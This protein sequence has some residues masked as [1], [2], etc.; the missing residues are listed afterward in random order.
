MLDARQQ[1]CQHNVWKTNENTASKLPLQVLIVCRWHCYM[2]GKNFVPLLSSSFYTL[3]SYSH[4][5]NCLIAPLCPYLYNKPKMAIF[6]PKSCEEALH[7][8]SHKE[9]S[10]NSRATNLEQTDLPIRH[11]SIISFKLANR[12]VQCLTVD[13]AWAH[14]RFDDVTQ[15]CGWNKFWGLRVDC[16]GFQLPTFRASWCSSTVSCFSLLSGF[17]CQ[18]I[19]HLL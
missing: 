5:E 19:S 8:P 9:A 10:R 13:R 1:W 11:V 2:H 12:E 17:S 16:Q 15:L 6:E 4:C 7:L 3:L 14:A 18:S